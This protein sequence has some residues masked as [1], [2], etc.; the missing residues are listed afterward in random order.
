MA[1]CRICDAPIE[2]FIDFGRMPLANAF[3]TPDQFAHEYFFQLIAA[4]CPR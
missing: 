4:Y 3:L 1:G 2:P